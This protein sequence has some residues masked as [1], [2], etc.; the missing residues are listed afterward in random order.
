MVFEIEFF[1]LLLLRVF[2]KLNDQFQ[3][4]EEYNVYLKIEEALGKYCPKQD[5]SLLY[6]TCENNPT[7]CH[8][9]IR[10]RKRE[11]EEDIS[12][13]YLSEVHKLTD[14]LVQDWKFNKA[15]IS[16]SNYHSKFNKDILFYINKIIHNSDQKNIIQIKLTD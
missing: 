12:F 9:R 13:E 5:V 8:D 4:R 3:T 10:K 11:G 1:F 16:T 7:I 15:C 14:E 2:F 6:L